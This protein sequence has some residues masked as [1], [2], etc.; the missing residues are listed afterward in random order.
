MLKE[1]GVVIQLEDGSLKAVSA[2]EAR[3]H[4][5]AMSLETG[6]FYERERSV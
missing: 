2:E 3:Q 4:L 5:V 6:S 1:A